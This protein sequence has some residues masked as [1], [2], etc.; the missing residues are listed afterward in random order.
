MELIKQGFELTLADI[1]RD[2]LLSNDFIN[3][4]FR[5]IPNRTT[6]DKIYTI[7]GGA[8]T[9]VEAG[10]NPEFVE[11]AVPSDQ[12]WTIKEGIIAKKWCWTQFADF[13]RGSNV[14]DTQSIEVA[15]ETITN[16][17]VD[18]FA[19]TIAGLMLLGDTATNANPK[20][21]LINGLL[22][23]AYK[24]VANGATERRTEITTN[25]KT[26]LYTGRTTIDLLYNLVDDAPE[27]V[28]ANINNSVLIVNDLLFR[29]LRYNYVA[30]GFHIDDQLTTMLNGFRHYTFDG[31]DVIVVPQIDTVLA[32]ATVN[33]WYYQKA[34]I[35]MLVDKGSALYATINSDS[36]SEGAVN[37]YNDERTKE[38]L[39]D[40]TYS[41]GVALA[42][43]N[44][45]IA[46]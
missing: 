39:V 40:V 5:H 20:Y 4:I 18:S 10:C 19:K 30:L 28:K 33:D 17:M 21:K 25:T 7:P 3:S 32:S 34:G 37:T 9:S 8:P 29:A 11:G 27:S 1:L 42:S 23:Q 13:K 26:A 15:N 35:A 22:T 36:L 44:F 14:L 41:I 24:K 2:G 46:Y 31:I 43:D 38:T 12:T 16:V 45:Q 6:G